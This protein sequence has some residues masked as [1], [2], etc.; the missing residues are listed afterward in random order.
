MI[1]LATMGD[2]MSTTGHEKAVHRVHPQRPRRA[3][4]PKKEKE[5]HTHS[6]AGLLQPER[7]WRLKNHAPRTLGA[8]QAWCRSPAGKHGIFTSDGGR[9]TKSLRHS[10]L[11]L[12]AAFRLKEIK[13]HPTQGPRS[14]NTTSG[15]GVICLNLFVRSDT[16]WSGTDTWGATAMSREMNEFDHSHGCRGWRLCERK[17]ITGVT[18]CLTIVHQQLE[19]TFLFKSK[20]NSLSCGELL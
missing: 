13:I 6:A 9:S 16:T 2:N 14:L 12:P 8:R 11:L 18:D 10:H 7:A 15:P 17:R 19:Y 4:H 1:N 5:K 20:E 3:S